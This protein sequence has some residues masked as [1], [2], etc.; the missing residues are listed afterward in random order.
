MYAPATMSSEQFTSSLAQLCPKPSAFG[1][2]LLKF[3]Q[4]V[5]GNVNTGNSKLFTYYYDY[6]HITC[7]APKQ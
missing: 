2:H 5:L 3:A 4:E 6:F 1:K 7:L